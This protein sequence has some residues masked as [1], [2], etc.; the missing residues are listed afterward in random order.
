MTL[1]K[2]RKISE[3][4]K[5]ARKSKSKNIVMVARLDIIKDQATLIKAFSKLNFP[6]W[7]LKIV[8]QGSNLN[9]LRDLAK[10]HSL[11]PDE[12]FIGPSM[13]IPK[14]LGESEIFAFSTTESEGFGIVLIEAMAANLPI[15]ASDVSAC[16][17]VLLD[18]KAG[19]L[20]SPVSV[21]SWIKNL[22]KLIEDS[23]YRNKLTENLSDLVKVYDSKEIALKWEKLL[24]RELKNSQ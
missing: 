5:S 9:Y 1:V 10:S 20:V 6:N 23:S 19:L 13:N 21:R 16:R 2:I 11:N 24:K 3:I 12:I 15:I 17:E 22:K 14:L 4:S 8:G 18:G 7:K